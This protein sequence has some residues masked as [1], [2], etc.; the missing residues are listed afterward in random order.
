MHHH[1]PWLLL[2][3]L[4]LKH[5]QDNVRDSLDHMAVFMLGGLLVS[6]II[7]LWLEVLALTLQNVPVIE[8]SLGWE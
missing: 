6:V 3:D 8:S 1:E 4:V 5:V 2:V 7:E